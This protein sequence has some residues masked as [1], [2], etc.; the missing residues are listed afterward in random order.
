MNRETRILVTGASGLLGREVMR[1]LSLRGAVEGWAYR[2]PA[3]LERVNLL[4]GEAAATAFR[5]F[6]PQIVVHAAAERW[7]DAM[8]QNREQA[9]A[10]NVDV[11]ENLARLAQT[12]GALFIFIST[13]YVFDGLS[14]PYNEQDA[15]NPLNFYAESKVEAE[16]GIVNLDSRSCILRIPILYGPSTDIQESSITAMLKLLR[17]AGDQ[18]VFFDDRDIRYPTYTPDVA[19]AI[20]FLIEKEATGIYHY[21]AEEPFTKYGMVVEIAR[22]SGIPRHRIY[23]DPNPRSGARRP[24]NAH[25]NNTKIRRLGFSRYTRFHEGIASVLRAFQ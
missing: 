23:P 16:K 5:R 3:N 24:L 12:V 25:L 22:Q 11:A 2:R 13:D 21:T 6:R 7:P 20:R 8:E 4:D 18:E 14:P 17:D 10:L 9:W 1:V 15:P 19:E